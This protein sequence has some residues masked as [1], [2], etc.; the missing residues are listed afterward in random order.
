MEVRNFR[1]IVPEKKKFG[2]DKKV[3]FAELLD[4]SFVV[5]NYEVFPSKYEG[6]KE[7]AVILIQHNGGEAVTTI[8]SRVIIDQLAKMK[9]KMPVSVQLQRRNKYFTFS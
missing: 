2:V 1:E 7:F 9:D 5:L 6:C 4:K 8:S 3:P